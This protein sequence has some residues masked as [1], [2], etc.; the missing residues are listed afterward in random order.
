LR[1]FGRVRRT[2]IPVRVEIFT[3]RGSSSIS[4]LYGF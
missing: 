2:S 4:K 1:A 3:K